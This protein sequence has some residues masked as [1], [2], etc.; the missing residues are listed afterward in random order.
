MKQ[1]DERAAERQRPQRANR[2]VSRP[3]ARAD[4]GHVDAILALQAAA[5]NLAVGT[6]I[7]RAP[8]KGGHAAGAAPGAVRADAALL[9][10]NVSMV[11]GPTGKAYA[12]ADTAA[13]PADEAQFMRH[14]Y[15]VLFNRRFGGSDAYD[16]PARE[17]EADFAAARAAM[18][19]IGTRLALDPSGGGVVRQLDAALASSA[20]SVTYGAMMVRAGADAELQARLLSRPVAEARASVVAALQS[21]WKSYSRFADLVQHTSAVAARSEGVG[22][23]LKAT[24]LGLDAI[25]K[26]AKALDPDSY[27]KAVNEAREWCHEHDAG[28][29]MGTVRAVQ[30][31]AEM[32]ELTLGTLNGVVKTMAGAA[33]LVLAPGRNLTS[34]VEETMKALEALHESG[35]L[36]SSGGRAALK[37]GKVVEK[38]EKF[39]KVLSVVS[40][41]GGAAKM[42]TADSNFERVDAGIDIVTGGMQVAGKL[43]TREGL[44]VGLGAA[45]SSVLMTWEMVKFFGNMG[46]DAI[47]GSMWGGLMQELPEIEQRADKVA[48]G[49]VSLTRALDERNARFGAADAMSPELAGANDAVDQLAYNL[50]KD[51]RAADRRWRDSHIPALAAAYHGPTRQSVMF[52][53]Q[54]G[55]PADGVAQA[56]IEFMQA[57]ADAFRDAPDIVDDMLVDQGYLDREKAEKRKRERAKQRSE[58]THGGA[59]AE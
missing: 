15:Q 53:L 49:L 8:A 39:E 2:P 57:L 56:T 35:E 47:E 5:G 52:A 1:T 50:Q 22:S 6:I 27:L 34:T 38:L 7:Q 3:L 28:A 44:K 46:L 45:A 4:L 42:A 55:Y 37:L 19:A 21:G 32:V 18:P 13:L 59:K 31:E 17:R 26:V 16:L 24:H 43:V 48:V 11:L 30:V 33:V 40:I 51:L 29:V 12:P 14:L 54:D 25:S 36:V 20:S 23:A 41:V 10:M 9:A 58:A